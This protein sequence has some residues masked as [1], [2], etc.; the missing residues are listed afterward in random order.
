MM[1]LVVKLWLLLHVWILLTF[2]FSFLFPIFLSHFVMKSHR[3]FSLSLS[4]ILAYSFSSSSNSCISV[5]ISLS[6]PLLPSSSFSQQ[7]YSGHGYEVLDARAS[8]D[9]G[10]LCSCGGDK[11]VV[12]WD[13]AS[14]KMMRKYRG[15]AGRVN[16]VCFNEEST[17]IFSG[18]FRIDQGEERGWGR[19]VL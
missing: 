15:H 2:S 9:N 14:G 1:C 6:L 19:R 17:I 3:S 13:V 8:I 7:T 4:L 5:Y 12:L 18:K 16:C 10:H 11:T